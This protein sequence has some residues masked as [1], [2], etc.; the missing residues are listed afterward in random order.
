LSAA[1]MRWTDTIQ[2]IGKQHGEKFTDDDVNNMTWEQKSFWLRT[3]PVSAARHFDHRLQLFVN[4][5]LCGEAHP[6]GKIVD[7]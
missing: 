5:V 4:D 7:F 1:D 2:I 6:V 3:N